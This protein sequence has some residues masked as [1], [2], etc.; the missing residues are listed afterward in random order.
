MTKKNGPEKKRRFDRRAME[1]VSAKVNQ[2]MQGQ[3]FASLEEANMFLMENACGLKLD[4][5]AY[6]PKTSLEQA[7]YIMW[8]AFDEPSKKK[9]IA[10]ADQA[11][12]I[13]QDCADAYVVLAEDRSRN[14]EEEIGF[15]R[16]G[17]EAGKR[18]LGEETLQSSE[19]HFWSDLR[20]RPYMRA[21]NGLACALHSDEQFAEA[22]ALW[23]ELLRLNPNDNQGVRTLLAPALV[24]ANLLAEAEDLFR[25]YAGETS[26]HMMY[27]RALCRFKKY[28]DS[29]LAN[30]ALKEAMEEN[31]HVLE[32]LWGVRKLPK[33][34]PASY[35]PGS[36][37]EAEGYV[38]IA[39]HSWIHT[40]RAIDWIADFISR[41][42]QKRRLANTFPGLIAEPSSDNVVDINS[43]RRR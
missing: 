10:M 6:Q 11:L 16:K 43:L 40:D 2:L 12:A 37:E 30:D 19:T 20:T 1:T 24:E 7:Q 23:K 35:S 14:I 27:S 36:P 28:G 29:P 21:I 18:A 41:A 26:A 3:N 17:V 22:I 13:S 42:I 33:R 38:G 32:L 25:A 34:Q 5:F 8:D 15:Y 39:I 4:E 31:S 9:R